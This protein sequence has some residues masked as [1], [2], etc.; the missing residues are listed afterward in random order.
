M[1]QSEDDK[2]I[3]AGALESLKLLHARGLDFNRKGYALVE[4]LLIHIV[5][6]CKGDR[7]RAD[8]LVT[9]YMAT[10]KLNVKLEQDR[11]A[12]E[13]SGSE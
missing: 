7:S 8:A 6:E 9:H 4:A 3:E 11:E 12:A 13:G 10:L 2:I 1:A 5:A